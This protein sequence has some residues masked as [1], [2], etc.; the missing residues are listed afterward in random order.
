MRIKI[1]EFSLRAAPADLIILL[2][3][4]LRQRAIAIRLHCH[5]L[6]QFLHPL[7]G[8]CIV[9]DCRV[10]SATTPPPMI[11]SQQLGRFVSVPSEKLPGGIK[12]ALQPSSVDRLRQLAKI[13]L[14]STIRGR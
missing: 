10:D 12:V 1:F 4:G 9:V 6:T 2:A 8:K 14:K 7:E 11:S 13:L 3:L 5:S